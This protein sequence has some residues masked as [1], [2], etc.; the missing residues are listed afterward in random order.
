MGHLI[1]PTQFRLGHSVFSDRNWPALNKEQYMFCYGIQKDFTDY[2]KSIFLFKKKLILKRKHRKRRFFTKNRNPRLLFSHCNVNFFG[3]NL[4]RVLVDVNIFD[5]RF[6]S[7]WESLFDTKRFQKFLFNFSQVFRTAK[8]LRTPTF[9]INIKKETIKQFFAILN[10]QYH[11]INGTLLS[12]TT[13][14]V[15][16]YLSK[17]YQKF[18][19]FFTDSAY[20]VNKRKTL[21][22]AKR[23]IKKRSA[24]AHIFI[25]SKYKKRQKRG[26]LKNWSKAFLLL[27]PISARFPSKFFQAKNK[28]KISKLKKMLLIKNKD[29][30]NFSDMFDLYFKVITHKF[31]KKVRRRDLS[32]FYSLVES[33]KI[34]DYLKSIKK[35]F[36]FSLRR[37]ALNK[38][39][40]SLIPLEDKFRLYKCQAHYY[41][42]NIV[43]KKQFS[44][45][46]R[47][48]RLIPAVDLDRKIMKKFHAFKKDLALIENKVN[49]QHINKKPFTRSTMVCGLDTFLLNVKELLSLTKIHQLQVKSLIDMFF[50]SKL[51]YPVINFEP[52]SENDHYIDFFKGLISEFTYHRNKKKVVNKDLL[53]F[54]KLNFFKR[55]YTFK[56]SLFKENNNLN[57]TNRKKIV[58]K[59]AVKTRKKIVQTRKKNIPVNNKIVNNLNARNT[60]FTP[61]NKHNRYNNF[62]NRNYKP[63]TRTLKKYPITRFTSLSNFKL[64]SSNYKNI[65]LNWAIFEGNFW[66]ERLINHFI[67][68]LRRPEQKEYN[69]IKSDLI[70]GV[71]LPQ[72]KKNN[73]SRTAHVTEVVGGL[74]Y[75][76]IKRKFLI[77]DHNDAQSNYFKNKLYLFNNLHNFN[78]PTAHKELTQTLDYSDRREKFLRGS[79]LPEPKH[80]YANDRKPKVELPAFDT[81][82]LYKNYESTSILSNIDPSISERRSRVNY[83]YTLDPFFQKYMKLKKIKSLLVNIAVDIGDQKMITAK[84]LSYWLKSLFRKGRKIS[85]V[86]RTLDRFI[87]PSNNYIG[88]VS[89][90]FV[91]R[92]TRSAYT[93]N[94][95][96]KFGRLNNGEILKQMDYDSIEFTTKFGMC[97]IKVK[98]QYKV[99]VFANR[100]LSNYLKSSF[101]G[102]EAMTYKFDENLHLPMLMKYGSKRLFRI[103][104]NLKYKNNIP[105]YQ[106]K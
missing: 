79:S 41:L 2:F 87:R 104:S 35:D 6:E 18:F 30:F 58:K 3:F 74:R 26:F 48:I 68:S 17:I 82:R 76:F 100:N 24:K 95:Y 5:L 4:N 92:F 46:D 11:K 75:N 66:V 34:I 23:Y 22:Q 19:S 88:A 53:K 94:K 43:L 56:N 91:G 28:K 20:L 67:T 77:W 71:Y 63:F 27:S 69:K 60:K 33:A 70:T 50:R 7:K 32:R 72:H 16:S 25:T 21:R 59:K 31:A 89:V 90:L 78:F 36:K 96:Y 106:F 83:H 99:N 73:D 85:Y 65:L 29:L 49:I 80:Q 97:G 39:I 8:I 57:K 98:I 54:V 15:K 51:A 52:N 40:L 44:S 9:F 37:L 13:K 64:K 84:F 105:F 62:F 12:Q 45:V 61:Y 93:T 14:W 81:D 47:Y 101:S 103:H 102:S 10:V 42:K 86:L 55:S 38:P 1:N